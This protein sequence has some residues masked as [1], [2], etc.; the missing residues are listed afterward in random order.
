MYNVFGAKWKKR[1][2]NAEN[3]DPLRAP[4]KKRFALSTLN[5]S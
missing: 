1:E 4:W 3:R 5:G 2:L